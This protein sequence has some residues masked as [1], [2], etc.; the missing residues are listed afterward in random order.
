MCVWRGQGTNF[1]N[2]QTAQPPKKQTARL[3]GKANVIHKLRRLLLRWLRKV[4]WGRYSTAT[5]RGRIV[6]R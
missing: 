6:P 4:N 2:V 3:R 5:V 1:D